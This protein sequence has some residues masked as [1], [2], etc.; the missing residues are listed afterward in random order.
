MDPLLEAAKRRLDAA[1]QRIKRLD[2]EVAKGYLE[3]R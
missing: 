2:E 3:K 1:E